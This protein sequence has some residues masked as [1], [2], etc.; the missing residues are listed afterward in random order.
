M[1]YAGI[2]SRDT[3]NEVY[4]LFIKIGKALAKRGYILRSG[5]ADGSDMA[6]EVGCDAF[7]GKKEIYIPWS[8]FN[9]STSKL[10]VEN[11][12]AFEIAEKYH[13][14]WQNLKD[15]ARKLQARNSHQVL[16]WGLDT[17]CDFIICYTEGGKLKG[18]TA[19]ALR[20]AKDY[21]IKVFNAGGYGD[22]KDFINDINEFIKE[23]ENEG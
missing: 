17:P 7:S 10:V 1:I 8:G 5:H 12:K 16:G 15:G 21:D 9:G 13:P 3:P 2:G 22:L 4:Q 19:Q 20:I 14:Y 11:P 18:G 23:R 6:F